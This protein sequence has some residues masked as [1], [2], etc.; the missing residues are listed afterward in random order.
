MF[1]PTKKCPPT[2]RVVATSVV[3]KHY[4]Q[5]K[6]TFKAIYSRQAQ[7][8]CQVRPDPDIRTSCEPGY[9]PLDD[10]HRASCHGCQKHCLAGFT[11]P[12]LA[13]SPWICMSNSNRKPEILA[14]GKGMGDIQPLS[15]AVL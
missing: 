4:L 2:T 7:V 14:A 8:S 3:A 10:A 5:R 6:T 9:P 11:P 12:L 13:D 1:P 15:A